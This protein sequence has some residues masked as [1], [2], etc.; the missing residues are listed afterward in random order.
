MT[1]QQVCLALL[2]LT[3][4]SSAA[5]AI[6][7]S[8][9]PK[10]PPDRVAPFVAGATITAIVSGGLALIVLPLALRSKGAVADAPA[11]GV[12]VG[13]VIPMLLVAYGGLAAVFYD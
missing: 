5:L 2:V 12:R 1:W 13:K 3:C 7:N 6:L 10:R 11:G 4:V 9:S 8:V